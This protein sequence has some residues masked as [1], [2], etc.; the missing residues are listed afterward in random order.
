MPKIPK[1]I[2]LIEN[3][4]EPGRGVLRGIAKYSFIRGPW[5]FYTKPPFYFN[6]VRSKKEL[7]SQ[8]KEFDPDGIITRDS[9]DVTEIASRGVPAIVFNAIKPVTAKTPS[10]FTDDYAI[11]KMAAEH[12]LDRGFAQFAF[13]G[14][15][16]IPWSVARGKAFSKRI[17]QAGLET[18]LYKISKSQSKLSWSK[19]RLLLA[20]WLKKLPKPLGLMACNDDR[21]QQ[22]AEACKIA[23]LHIPEQVAIIGVDNDDM[24]CNLT[25]PQLSSIAV[26]WERAGYEA[27]ELLDKLM[28]GKEK[29]KN[30]FI[31]VE[32]LYPVSR[33]STDILAIEDTDI[34]K[35]VRFIR[36]HCKEPIRV[37]DVV[38]AVA[39][40]RRILE[41]RFRKILGRSVLCEIRRVRVEQIVR[42]LIGTN[43]P[44]SQ[45]ASSLGYPGVD[46]IA[47][48]FRKEKAMTPL[49]YRKKFGNK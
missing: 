12:L 49:A 21:A 16:N 28:T 19:E 7:I 37:D 23:G 15:Y 32:P 25:N 36:Q 14:F 26:G 35:A 3:S 38:A 8:M 29:M 4:R 27:A 5:T 6:P 46:H 9:E 45:I 2:L 22:V 40:S 48:Y 42:M 44:I 13:C 20:D 1:V 30:Q 47:R 39:L 18:Y 10:I 31:K 33:Q 24:V 11:G 41:K 34:A 43:L 17:A